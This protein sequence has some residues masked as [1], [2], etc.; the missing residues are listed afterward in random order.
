MTFRTSTSVLRLL[1][2]LLVLAA[3]ASPILGQEPAESDAPGDALRVFL[4][5]NARNCDRTYFRTEIRFVSWVRDRQDADVHVIMTSEDTGGGGRR[6]TFDFIGLGELGGMEDALTFAEDRTDT[7]AEVLEGLTSTLSLGLARYAATVGVP[8]RFE[9]SY[10]PAEGEEDTIQGSEDDPWNFWIFVLDGEVEISGE[11]HQSFRELEGRVSAS[12][13]TE[14]WKVE[15]DVTADFRREEFELSDTSTF[16][17]ETTDWGARSLT[18]RSLTPHWSAGLAASVTSSTFENRDI[19]YRIAPALEWNY[20]PYL[21]ANRRQ[22]IVLYQVGARWVEY[23]E[24]T[25]FGETEEFLVDQ[26]VTVSYNQREEWGQARL[27]V[28]GSHFF[29]DLSKWRI[30]GGG[31]VDYRIFRG[32]SVD[33]SGEVAWVQDQLFLPAE[34]ATDEEILLERRQR[35]TDFE[36]ELEV[37]F[38]FQFG[39]IFNN[40]VNNRFPFS[41][42]RFLF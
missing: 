38:R 31:R 22:L 17:N 15:L 27:T 13:V 16:V 9:V 18:V 21:E 26:A 28:L 1:L 30:A 7:Q 36:F 40:V 11:E 29:H 14:E 37:G 34:G 39:S 20:F 42:R 23:E 2:P 35:A 25:I 10:E 19:G 3:S 8:G 6:Y 33:V 41:V 32:L 5:C 24:M 12:R 4:D